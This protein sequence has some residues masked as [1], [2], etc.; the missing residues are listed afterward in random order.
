MGQLR[1][2]K[3]GILL[4]TAPLLIWVSMVSPVCSQTAEKAVINSVEERLDGLL[5]L[6]FFSV[7]RYLQQCIDY[8]YWSL[9]F[10]LHSNTVWVLEKWEITGNQPQRISSLLEKKFPVTPYCQFWQIF[11]YFIILPLLII[12]IRF[13]LCKSN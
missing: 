5:N 2:I 4:K 1:I 9:G 12:W 10:W 3:F 11:S 13:F 7:E 6:F 8:S